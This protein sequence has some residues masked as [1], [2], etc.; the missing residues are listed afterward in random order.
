[1]KTLEEQILGAGNQAAASQAVQV[2]VEHAKLHRREMV[3]QVNA[4]QRLE[5]YVPDAQLTQLQE[6]F[7]AGELAPHQMI[8]ILTDYARKIRENLELEKL[9]HEQRR[10]FEAIDASVASSALSGVTIDPNK[11]LIWKKYVLDGMGAQELFQVI[12]GDKEK[13]ISVRPQPNYHDLP[14]MMHMGNGYFLSGDDPEDPP[15]K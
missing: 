9:T 10:L 4:N 1:M 15:V 3:D 7:I 8:E 12:Q 11:V 5:G 2:A 6:R 14:G 13:V